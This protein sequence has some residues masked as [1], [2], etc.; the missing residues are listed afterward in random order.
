MPSPAASPQPAP[1]FSM[2]PL[3]HIALPTVDPERC[4]CFYREVLGFRLV[5][6]PSFSFDG[7]WLYREGTHVMIHLLH[8]A[9]HQAR[10]GPINT[11]DTHFALQCLDIDSAITHL[12]NWGIETVE[13][14]L[15]DH[16]YRQIFF[17]DPDGNVIEM[18]EWP[19]AERLV[20]LLETQER[21]E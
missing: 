5:K 9:D 16:G 18:G 15:P 1:P 10:T 2:G 11:R 20:A 13:R 17:R 8:A 3:N 19:E 7:R 12:S 14:I 21:T 4:A 6:R